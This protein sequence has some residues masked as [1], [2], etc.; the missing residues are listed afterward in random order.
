L[1]KVSRLLQS[2]RKGISLVMIEEQ[3]TRSQRRDFDSCLLT[4][5]S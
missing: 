3:P 2:Y 5:V 4:P 1:K